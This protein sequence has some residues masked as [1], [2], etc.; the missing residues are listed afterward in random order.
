MNRALVS[1]VTLIVRSQLTEEP[2][3]IHV[4]RTRVRY[5][6]MLAARMSLTRVQTDALVLSAWLSGLGEKAGIVR[7]LTTPYALEE[8]L[9]SGNEKTK[10]TQRIESRILSLV[11]VYEE[12]CT[13]ESDTGRDV[14]RV[15]RELQL[16]WSSSPR[17][18]EL[19]EAF[20]QILVDEE[21]LE[22][23]TGADGRILIVDPEE[24]VTCSL[25]PALERVGYSAV[26]VPNAEAALAALN[27][28]TPDLVVVD[29]GHEST[30]GLRLIES[31][32]YGGGTQGIGILALVDDNADTLAAESLRAGADDYLSKPVNLEI[33]LL[34]VSASTGGERREADVDGVSGSLEEMGFTDMIQILCAGGKNLEIVLKEQ[35]EEGSVYV[36]DGKVVHAKADQLEGEEAFYALMRWRSGRFNTRPCTEFPGCTI[37]VSTMS[38]LMEGSRQADEATTPA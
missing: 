27:D 26:A 11:Q 28:Y 20:L 24:E 9:V 36:R 23:R 1:A 31:L 22:H 6:Q 29:L 3:D 17:N 18:Q 7:Q 38:L 13:D 37:E 21:F 12:L 16:K 10:R 4:V 2:Q 19:L 34:K 8:I 5:C 35:E 30:N 32:K 14:A 25:V 33:L 15:R